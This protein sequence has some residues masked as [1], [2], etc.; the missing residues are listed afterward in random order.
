M[1]I[2]IIG[3]GI[4][5]LTAGKILSDNHEVTILEKQDNIGG[6]ARVKDVNGISYHLTGGHCLNSKNEE[7]MNYIFNNVLEKEKWHQVIRKAK[8]SL[9][10]N[11]ISYPIEF[12]VKEIF[13]FNDELALRIIEDFI[14]AVD[15]PTKNLADW[16][17][18]KFGQ[19]LAEEY[20]IPYNK[21]IW[22]MN[23]FEMSHKWV[24]GKLPLPNKKAFLKSLIQE[25]KD[26]MPHQTFYYPNSNTQNTFIEALAKNLNIIKNF[27][28]NS[29]EKAN[30]KWIVN[31]E[32]IYDS[33]IS[34]MPLDVLPKI[35]K[36]TPR[37]IL[38]ETEKLKYNKVSNMLWKTKPID[39]TWT[40]YP[41]ED[42]IFHRH[43]HIGNFFLPKKNITITECVGEYS[44]DEMVKD[45]KN[46][47]Y[48]IEP[49]DFHISNH[50]YIVYDKNYSTSTKKI[51]EYLK[52]IG[53]YSLG[54]FGEWE[55]YNMDVCM[56]SAFNLAKTINKN[57]CTT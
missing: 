24:E 20:F 13:K 1:K 28:V 22:K 31:N 9:D 57:K 8:I 40:Y 17:V 4:S 30:N 25:V 56:Q 14:K 6:I 16:F 26:S 5:G 15:K 7:I 18:S 34:T 52:Q 55:Y 29:I 21:K 49:L 12:S 50:A 19:T 39:H 38:K 43:I 3:A 23:P 42:T 2:C 54:R 46:F 10:N 53:I 37:E 41:S 27:R 45:G 33:I 47:E 48:L 11:L 51:K 44:Y 36:H 35:L 32:Q